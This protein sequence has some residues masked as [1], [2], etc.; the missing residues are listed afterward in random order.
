[1]ES[2]RTFSNIDEYI[3]SFPQDVQKILTD[4]RTTIRAAAPGAKET[5]KYDI[6]TYMLHGNVIHFAA[7]K[8]HIS[9]FPN[10]A[11]P[12]LTDELA[13]YH[14]GKGTLQFPIKESMPLELIWRIARARVKEDEEKAAGKQKKS[15]VFQ[16]PE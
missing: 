15:R 2:K 16:H 7:Y 1:M 10:P 4:I 3:S 6:P 11:D 12:T 9:I 5:I 13:K 8:E 14:A